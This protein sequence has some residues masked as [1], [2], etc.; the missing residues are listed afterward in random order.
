MFNF[1]FYSF[2]TASCSYGNVFSFHF[3]KGVHSSFSL[4][5]SFFCFPHY[6]PVSPLLLPALVCRDLNSDAKG[7]LTLFLFSSK[8][9][10]VSLKPRQSFWAPL[11]LHCELTSCL[12][13]SSNDRTW[14]C[15][16][17]SGGINHAVSPRATPLLSCLG[18]LCQDAVCRVR[19]GGR[20]S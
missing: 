9:S 20:S 5:L 12:E 11:E 8:T 17:G 6:F 4:F 3:S 13:Y 7:S 14:R 2:L 15:F 1:L 18:I 16:L 19:E 10:P